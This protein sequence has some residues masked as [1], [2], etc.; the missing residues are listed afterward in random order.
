[1]A[2]INSTIVFLKIKYKIRNKKH[3]N[4]KMPKTNTNRIA[5]QNSNNDN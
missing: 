2:K 4:S 5:Q 1:M 3:M